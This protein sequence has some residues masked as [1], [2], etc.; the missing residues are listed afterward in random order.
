M[1]VCV[2][3]CMR[4][5]VHVCLCLCVCVCV[6]L[7]VSV[8]VCACVRVCMPLA[9]PVTQGG[10]QNGINNSNIYSALS[11]QQTP[12]PARR[13]SCS[14]SGGGGRSSRDGSLTDL[15]VGGLFSA[16]QEQEDV[17]LKPRPVRFSMQM[18]FCLLGAMH[19]CHSL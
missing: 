17:V 2:R 11:P 5:C 16:T 9:T 6:C 14:S 8:Y 15:H 18:S 7:C 3:S 19:I 1:C 10:I 12:T 13:T 4:A